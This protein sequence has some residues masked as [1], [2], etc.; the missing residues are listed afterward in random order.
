MLGNAVKKRE[1]GKQKQIAG[2]AASAKVSSLTPRA[3]PSSGFKASQRRTVRQSVKG[4]SS[5]YRASVKSRLAPGGRC[6]GVHGHPR[7]AAKSR[8]VCSMHTYN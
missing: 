7:K 3:L 8:Q 4:A 5:S 1:Y 6:G 2:K